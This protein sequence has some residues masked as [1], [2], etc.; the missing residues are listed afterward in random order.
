MQDETA[1]ARGRHPRRPGRTSPP[2]LDN[3]AI[4][5][6]RLFRD[7]PA[8]KS[9]ADT[10]RRRAVDRIDNRENTRGIRL[11]RINEP[12]I[13]VSERRSVEQ[14]DWNRRCDRRRWLRLDP[15]ECSKAD[16][17]CEEAKYP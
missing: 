4:V 15:R 3:Q 16:R 14:R 2:V 13:E 6:I 5:P 1:V 9:S 17:R 10:N 12:G 11:V 7:Q 8:E